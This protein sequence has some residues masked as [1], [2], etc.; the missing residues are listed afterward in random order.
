MLSFI[1]PTYNEEK[2]LSALL[3]ELK[4]QMQKEDEIIVVDSYS[5]D[6]KSVV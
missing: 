5:K 4:K 2:N 3:V 6:R 1:I